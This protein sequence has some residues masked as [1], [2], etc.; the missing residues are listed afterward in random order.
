MSSIYYLKKYARRAGFLF[1]V[2]VQYFTIARKLLNSIDSFIVL[3]NQV[4]Q[5]FLSHGTMT[6]FLDCG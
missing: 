4:I 5:Y 3:S 6:P 1:D 2:I